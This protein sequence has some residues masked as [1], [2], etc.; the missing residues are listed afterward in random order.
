MVSRARERDEAEMTRRY[1]R[2]VAPI[3]AKEPHI[4]ALFKH[5]DG[6]DKSLREIEMLSGISNLSS[7]RS[8]KHSPRLDLFIAVCDSVGLLITLTMARKS[9]KSDVNQMELEI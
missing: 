7:W 5:I 1:H 8:G 9:R 6:L 4:I 3:K 2:T